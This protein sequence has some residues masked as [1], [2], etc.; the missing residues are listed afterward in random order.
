M[1][2]RPDVESEQRSGTDLVVTNPYWWGEYTVQ[3]KGLHRKDDNIAVFDDFIQYDP[4]DVDRLILTDHK[5]P[6]IYCFN[7]KTFLNHFNH[8]KKEFSCYNPNAIYIRNSFYRMKHFDSFVLN[9]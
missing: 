3:V 8:T 1:R 9:P 7:Y 6:E 5:K 2:L 4:K